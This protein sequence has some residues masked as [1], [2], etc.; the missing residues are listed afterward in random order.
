MLQAC[1]RHGVRRGYRFRLPSVGG[2]CG[3]L[4]VL[5]S[6][7]SPEIGA[8]YQVRVSLEAMA[9]PDVQRGDTVPVIDSRACQ[10]LSQDGITRAEP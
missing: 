8:D 5:E 7:Y 1:L 4:H 2:S 3:Q 9:Q 6:A 10:R